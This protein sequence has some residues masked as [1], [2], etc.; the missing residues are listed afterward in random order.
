MIGALETRAGTNTGFN[1]IVYRLDV[2]A[3]ASVMAR[4]QGCRA[5]SGLRRYST[6]CDR[7]Q[8]A[9][10]QF[11]YFRPII[12]LVSCQMYLYVTSGGLWSCSLEAADGIDHP[13]GSGTAASS[14]FQYC[15]ILSRGAM[16]SVCTKISYSVYAYGDVL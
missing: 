15:H 13:S 7:R 12:I 10:Y 4:L 8:G 6:S 3:T 1:R 2:L 11:Y 9:L 16:L 5:E 14:R